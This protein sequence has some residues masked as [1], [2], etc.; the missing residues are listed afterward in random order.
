MRRA[1]QL[2]SKVPN[3]AVR[4]ALENVL[5]WHDEP[6][7]ATALDATG[8]RY[9]GVATD[10]S[11]DGEIVRWVYAQITNLEYQALL[12]G[13]TTV[14]EALAKDSVIVGD[15][16]VNGGEVSQ[17]WRASV[18]DVPEDLR[19]TANSYLPATVRTFLPTQSREEQ[20]VIDGAP[21]RGGAL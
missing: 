6:Q 5:V 10:D 8:A 7:V 17:M 21:I 20:I 19:P 15:F 18:S 13:G 14:R 2:D 11:D 12:T 1:W 3:A 16:Y 9:L 4:L